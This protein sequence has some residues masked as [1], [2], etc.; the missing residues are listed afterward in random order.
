MNSENF[1]FHIDPTPTLPTQKCRFL[2]RILG[3]ALSY[4]NYAIALA[5]WRL[6]DWFFAIA[7][8]LLGIIIFGIIS[9]KIR[10]DAIPA[11]QHE[12]PYDDYAIATWYLYRTFCFT[13]PPATE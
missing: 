12:Y 9:S 5:I 11:A 13:I 10:N 3:W 2:A 1:T 4:G 8:L 7:S 6:F